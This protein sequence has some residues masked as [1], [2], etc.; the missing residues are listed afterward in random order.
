MLS[1]QTWINVNCDDVYVIS[2]DGDLVGYCEV[3]EKCHSLKSIPEFIGIYNQAEERPTKVAHD[4]VENEIEW[5]TDF[6][7]KEAINYGF[8]FEGRVDAEVLAVS[9][10]KVE[11]D[12]VNIIEIDDS[13]AYAVLEASF[14]ITAKITGDDHEHAIWDSEDKN[15]FIFQPLMLKWNSKRLTV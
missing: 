8:I 7:S 1:L 5:L 12:D 2:S 11:I 9:I 10:N 15:I 13:K 14:Y 4:C 6:I 3:N